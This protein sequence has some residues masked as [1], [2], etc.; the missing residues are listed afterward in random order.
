M[1]RRT[2]FHGGIGAVAAQLVAPS[3]GIAQAPGVR[4][5]LRTSR[6]FAP[7]AASAMEYGCQDIVTV[8]DALIALHRDAHNRKTKI[9]ATN[10]NGSVLWEHTLP[11]GVYLSLGTAKQ[12]T[13]I[14]LHAQS[15]VSP[16]GSV[17]RH[18][19]LELD[20]ATGSLKPLGSLES[21]TGAPVRTYFAGDSRL[22][23]VFADAVEFFRADGTVTLERKSRLGA[24]NTASHVDLLSPNSL[25]LTARDGTRVTTVDLPSG[26]T[27][28][29]ALGGLE[30][31]AARTAAQLLRNKSG[32]SSA[33]SVDVVALTGAVQGGKLTALLSPFPS[34]G[35]ASLVT[36]D[37][38]G[39]LSPRGLI[40]IH[41]ST[42]PDFGPPMKLIHVGGELGL[43]HAGGMVGWYDGTHAEFR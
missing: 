3:G 20:P 36:L 2:L 22:V 6:L 13:R 11:Q 23:R 8:N 32:M 39:L 33:V 40:R 12:S 17:G 35:A 27:V 16:D 15:Y 29:R 37:R 42:A 18:L 7:V 41:F 21:P 25:V 38:E 30:I 14:L 34:D 28:Q 1:K 19:G 26:Q 24:S 5:V 4:E 31:E 9:T 10:A 43:V